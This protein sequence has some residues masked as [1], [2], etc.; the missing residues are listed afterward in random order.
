MSYNPKSHF[1]AIDASGAG[2]NILVKKRAGNIIRVLNYVLIASGAVEATWKSGESGD[3]SAISG[4]MALEAPVSAASAHGLVQ[5]K[6][7][8]ALN[9]S[10]DAGTAVGGHLVYIEFPE[11]ADI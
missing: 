3:A 11:T 7:G 6:P 8:E 10:L 5:T 4:P 2:D 9:L 1:V